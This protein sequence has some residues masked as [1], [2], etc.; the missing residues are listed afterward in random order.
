MFAD[1][2]R[3][4]KETAV[5]M[6]ETDRKISK[7]EAV[8]N[9]Q[10]GRLV[11][12]LVN[13]GL[14][15]LF[16]QRGIAVTRVSRG[17]TIHQDGQTVAEIDV[18]VENGLE[19]IAVEVKTTCRVGDV[20]R[21]LARLEKVRNLRADYRDGIKKLY[22]AIAALKFDSEADEFAKRKGLF[23]LQS[24]EGL[25]KITNAEDFKPAS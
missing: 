17:Q 19:D 21:H 6:K 4:Q 18:L 13:S 15:A 14:P 22:G 12:A 24:K 25:F 5:Q 16:Q 2:A 9:A 1:L 7:L 20:K 10:W 11:E 8:F 3:F 23:V